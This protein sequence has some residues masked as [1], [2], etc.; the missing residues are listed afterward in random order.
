MKIEE[1]NELLLIEKDSLDDECMIYPEVFGKIGDE[2]VNAISIRDELKAESEKVW[3]KVLLEVKLGGEKVSDPTAKA[4]ADT[5]EVYIK[6]FNAYL[7]AKANAE[8][9]LIAKEKWEKK[10][11]MLRNLC[12]LFVSGYWGSISADSTKSKFNREE[13]KNIKKQMRG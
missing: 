11:V 4:M 1:I 12:D 6:A 2:Y 13:L 7:K 5:S 9:W 10:G 3:S 8:M